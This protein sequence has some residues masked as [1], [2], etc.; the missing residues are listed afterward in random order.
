[1]AGF[2]DFSGD[3]VRMTGRPE[4]AD[5]EA[6]AGFGGALGQGFSQFGEAM[7][8]NAQANRQMEKFVMDKNFINQLGQEAGVD[9]SMIATAN[10]FANDPKMMATFASSFANQ[11]KNRRI[12]EK[13]LLELQGI[14]ERVSS[15][16]EKAKNEV[17]QGI[18]QSNPNAVREAMESAYNQAM[19]EEKRRAQM[20]LDNETLDYIGPRIGLNVR[21]DLKD[22]IALRRLELQQADMDRK[23]EAAELRRKK[24]EKLRIDKLIKDAD[25]YLTLEV[26]EGASAIKS[27]VN[28]IERLESQIK[29]L[30][31]KPLSNSNLGN[32]AQWFTNNLRADPSKM[33][34]NS[35]AK[36][37][38]SKN[39]V[40]AVIN[41]FVSAYQKAVSGL[42]VSEGERRFIMQSLNLGNNASFG[43]FAFAMNTLI[44][45]TEDMIKDRLAE[46]NVLTYEDKDEERISLLRERLGELSN[47]GRVMGGEVPEDSLT[48][49][50]KAIQNFDFNGFSTDRTYDLANLKNDLGDWVSNLGTGSIKDIVKPEKPKTDKKP[51]KA[52][53]KYNWGLVPKNESTGGN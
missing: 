2:R 45:R 1:M 48:D 25:K 39:K 47:L 31:F 42:T 24:D 7:N 52:G 5:V 15:A 8:Q 14:S 40:N 32:M 30:A 16:V 38:S 13:G 19:E 26:K 36:W 44:E 51:S 33:D 29:D 3:I 4:T 10:Q 17:D 34:K 11:G 12:E 21:S 43:D 18:V 20:E 49:A 28:A 22:Q 46:Y 41:Q 6:I 37:S 23:S 53:N 9:P 27:S 35:I 50:S